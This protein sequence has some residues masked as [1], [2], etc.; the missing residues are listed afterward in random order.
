[1]LNLEQPFQKI[2]LLLVSHYH[3]DHFTP[4]MGFPFLMNH[5]ETRMIANEHTL[6]LVK[7]KDPDNYEKVKHQIVNRTPEWGEVQEVDVN[8]CTIK[9]YLEKHT[10]DT[11]LDREFI[12]T[13]FLIELEGLKILHMGDMYIPPNLEYFKNFGSLRSKNWRIYLQA[14]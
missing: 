14:I 4:D 1:M 3:P 13:Q 11:H 6:S 8:G 2:D 9:L 7:E 5:P 10:T 12:V